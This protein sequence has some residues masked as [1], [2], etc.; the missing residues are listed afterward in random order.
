[1]AAGRGLLD[2][3]SEMRADWYGQ[4]N[5]RGIDTEL[6]FPERGVPAAQAKAVCAGCVV[7]DACLEYALQNHERFGIW[8]GLSERERRRVRRAWLSGR[9]VAT[10]RAA[11]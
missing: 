3:L 4:A 7:R 8:G 6:F 10:T 1:M 9:A 5:C 2:L 11:S